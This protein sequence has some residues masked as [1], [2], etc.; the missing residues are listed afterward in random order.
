LG[1]VG[2]FIVFLSL[3]SLACAGVAAA[4]VRRGTG[5]RRSEIDGEMARPVREIERVNGRL[6]DVDERLADMTLMI[7]ETSRPAVEDSRP[8]RRDD[9]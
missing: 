1:F 4:V 3:F 8:L 9:A 2:L 6:N 5:H 7:D